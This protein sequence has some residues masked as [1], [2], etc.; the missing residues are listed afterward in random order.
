MEKPVKN[1]LIFNKFSV[2]YSQKLS[3]YFIVLQFIYICLLILKFMF[4][5]LIVT[6]IPILCFS[7]YGS[8]QIVSNN[9][10]LQGKYVEVGVSQCGSF[11]SSVCAPGTYHPRGT[12]NNSQSCQLGFIANPAK[13]NWSNY[14]GDYFLPGSP[15]EGWGL[16]VNGTNYNNNLICNANS[17]PG[18]FINYTTNAT[19]S[20]ATWQGSIAGLSITSRT[21]IPVNSVYFVT[22]V[23]IVN[24]SANTINNVYY[25][26]NVDPDHG[27]LT[28]GAGGSY[29]TNNSIVFQPPNTCSNALVSA[30]TLQG[31]FD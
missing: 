14:V 21:Y 28:P 31:S 22:E 1:L 8:S 10:F 17:I 12:G 11:G 3:E 26:R 9:A 7:F 18:S 23:T 20:S 29:S 24:T 19:Q 15:E 27:V 5:S 2:R 30:T 16:S 13:D 4:K 25:M 6:I